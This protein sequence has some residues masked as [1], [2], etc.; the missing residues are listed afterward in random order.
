[1][2]TENAFRL[3]FINFVHPVPFLDFSVGLFNF[4]FFKIVLLENFITAFKAV[5]KF[6]FGNRLVLHFTLLAYEVT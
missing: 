4:Q 5:I 6:A 1:M 3:I 2:I